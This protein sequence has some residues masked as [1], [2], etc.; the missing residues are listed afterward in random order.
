MQGQDFEH[1][2]TKDMSTW[3]ESRSL[4]KPGPLP[5][6]GDISGLR[7]VVEL[8]GADSP[9]YWLDSGALLGLVRDGREIS[10]DA[11]IDLGVWES[12]I[13]RLNAVLEGLR[14]RGYAVY[15]HRYR[16]RIYEF[17]LIDRRNRAFRPVHIHVYSRDGQIAWSP[18]TVTYQPIPGREVER[19]FTNERRTRAFLV[20][21]KDWAKE[22]RDDNSRSPRA[23]I[24]YGAWG[25]MVLVRNRLDRSLWAKLWPYSSIHTIYTWVVP[26]H[27]FLVLDKRSVGDIAVRIPSDVQSYLARRYGAWQVPVDDWCYWTD[28]GCIYPGH[29]NEVISRMPREFGGE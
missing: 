25:A 13:P 3:A 1:G 7:K 12:H 29:P 22:F 5:D 2:R 4:P 20:T 24:S 26:A 19:G 28:D 21:L 14:R 9:D 10:W 11:D 8:L 27:H 23:V 16:G 6:A 17:T 18:Q 15:P